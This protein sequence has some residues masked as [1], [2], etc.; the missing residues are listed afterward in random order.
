LEQRLELRHELRQELLQDWRGDDVLGEAAPDEFLWTLELILLMIK[1]DTFAEYSSLIERCLDSL[2]DINVPIY[3]LRAA[4]R[5]CEELHHHPSLRRA[6]S[7]I[8]SRELTHSLEYASSHSERFSQTLIVAASMA[9][10]GTSVRGVKLMADRA[11]GIARA[12]DSDFKWKVVD[13]ASFRVV[14]DY[15]SENGESQAVMEWVQELLG[16]KVGKTRDEA[17]VEDLE[18]VAASDETELGF[19]S[20]EKKI[21]EGWVVVQMMKAQKEA[22]PDDEAT[23]ERFLYLAQEFEWEEIAAQAYFLLSHREEW[24][25]R[26][27]GALTHF[28]SSYYKA[29]AA[30]AL[31]LAEHRA[32]EVDFMALIAA[33]GALCN[34]LNAYESSDSALWNYERHDVEELF[35]SSPELRF[36]MNSY[37]APPNSTDPLA[38]HHEWLSEQIDFDSV[39]MLSSSQM[40]AD[41]RTIVST[42]E[43]ALREEAEAVAEGAE[44]VADAEEELED[45]G[46]EEVGDAA[47]EQPPGEFSLGEYYPDFRKNPDLYDEISGMMYGRVG[48][49]ELSRSKMEDVAEVETLMRGIYEYGG[50]ESLIGALRAIP[51]A[52]EIG[53][54]KSRERARVLTEALGGVVDDES[55]T[56]YLARLF[57]TANTVYE[58]ERQQIRDVSSHMKK[59]LEVAENEDGISNNYVI[60]EMT[61]LYRAFYG[62]DGLKTLTNQ[63]LVH[64]NARI[65]LI[66]EKVGE[67]EEEQKWHAD[68]TAKGGE[69]AHEIDMWRERLDDAE[70]NLLASRVDVNKWTTEYEERKHKAIAKLSSAEQ[71]AT[72]AFV[73]ARYLYFLESAMTRHGIGGEGLFAKWIKD[74]IR[75]GIKAIGEIEHKGR[76]A[77]V[78]KSF[79]ETTSPR[80]MTAYGLRAKVLGAMD[81]KYITLDDKIVQAV[82]KR[83]AVDE[84]WFHGNHVA[85]ALSDGTLAP[86]VVVRIY[87]NKAINR[88][89]QKK[90]VSGAISAKLY[91]AQLK[92]GI[93]NP[94]IVKWLLPEIDRSEGSDGSMPPEYVDLIKALTSKGNKRMMSYALGK[95][96]AAMKAG[97]SG[98]SEND[99]VWINMLVSSKDFPIR[100]IEEWI[101]ENE[102][103]DPDQ[104]YIFEQLIDNGRFGNAVIEAYRSY[105]DDDRTDRFLALFRVIRRHMPGI[106]ITSELLGMVETALEAS[107]SDSVDDIVGEWGE[108]YALFERMGYRERVQVLHDDPILRLIYYYQNIGR[109]YFRNGPQYGFSE[110]ARDIKTLATT[111]R[112]YAHEAIERLWRGFESGGFIRGEEVYDTAVMRLH[113]IRSLSTDERAFVERVIRSREAISEADLQE[114]TRVWR[115]VD[116]KVVDVLL[117]NQQRIFYLYNG[118]APLAHDAR[119]RTED[120]GFEVEHEPG[121]QEVLS[122]SSQLANLG[123]RFNTQYQEFLDL[124]KV[125]YLLG[126]TNAEID[127]LEHPQLMGTARRGLSQVFDGDATPS[128]LLHDIYELL[129]RLSTYKV[130]DGIERAMAQNQARDDIGKDIWNYMNDVALTA[131]QKERSIFLESSSHLEDPALRL[132]TRE[133][134]FSDVLPQLSVFSSGKKMVKSESRAEVAKHLGVEYPHPD[135]RVA[136]EVNLLADHVGMDSGLRERF[137]PHLVESFTLAAAE[138]S[139]IDQLMNNGKSGSRRFKVR[140]IPRADILTYLQI[141]NF[142]PC[143]IS[144]DGTYHDNVLGFYQDLM[145]QPLVVYDADSN[146]GLGHMIGHLGLIGMQ[147]NSTGYLLNGSYMRVPHR[148]ADIDNGNLEAMAIFAE[149]AGLD[150]LLHGIHTYHDLTT[151][152]PKE[153]GRGEY[154]VTRLQ[155][156]LDASGKVVP[157]YNDLG[158]DGEKANRMDKAFFFYRRTMDI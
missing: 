158:L 29:K 132:H 153:F 76:R 113:D 31:K 104:L 75:L 105:K 53:G 77:H 43:E 24:R 28:E 11:F 60:S 25:S 39:S 129:I 106:D 78:V 64:A 10:S 108:R 131:M 66:K 119:G 151:S 146:E 99:L 139:Q 2:K 98:L 46:G 157:F 20:E 96:K 135:T 8:Y 109:T 116:P 68:D 52:L 79:L 1:S 143:C 58:N 15:L 91:R 5:L 59:Y 13:R 118:M 133:L 67:L 4:C 134:V 45:A 127:K 136:V 71:I 63:L 149:G 21:F 62:Y 150:T 50:H 44:P 124:M 156:V 82:A 87:D 19:S 54:D 14:L 47:S 38:N 18:E 89:V 12:S 37:R 85:E 107:A 122:V 145:T 17:P 7:Q 27:S 36:H 42:R 56:Y 73:R 51:E 16:S 65:K 155:T 90:R 142:R 130:E 138:Y 84:T 115:E 101:F 49:A 111:D 121:S 114:M 117:P 95:C 69:L 34:E 9:K 126:R 88:M 97:T 33:K 26:L 128:K 140:Y 72:S 35:S 112:Q 137:I 61:E 86:A 120:G 41:A 48:S 81:D 80:F 23:F 94:N 100:F 57:I 30:F 125:N 102:T 141:G 110:F 123:T 147:L 154:D 152:P 144:T 148:S 32:G 3:R 6:V 92:A 40:V 74:Y 70:A 83:D 103:L 22:A 55:Y 93:G